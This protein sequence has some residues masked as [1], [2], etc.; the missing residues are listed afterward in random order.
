M[1]ETIAELRRHLEEERQAREEAERRQGEAE[2]RVSECG[3]AIYTRREVNILI[4]KQRHSTYSLIERT[5]R[6]LFH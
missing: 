3:I 4:T 1:E 6:I 2:L 5:P